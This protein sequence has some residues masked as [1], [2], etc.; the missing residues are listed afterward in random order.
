MPA[1][2]LAGTL[3]FHGSLRP[4][5]SAALSSA[6]TTSPVAAISHVDGRQRLIFHVGAGVQVLV[7]RA[8]DDLRRH[9]ADA[10]GLAQ[11]AAEIHPVER[12]DD[13]GLAH[14][15]ARI[16]AEHVERR[17]VMRRMIGR[18][19][20]ALLEVGDHAGAEPLG[21]L[22]AR[23]PELGLARAAAEH[24]HRL[25]ARLAAA[26]PLRRRDSFAGRGGCRRLEALHVGPFRLLVELLLLEAGVETDVDRRGRRRAR[27]HV[28]A[29]HRFHQRIRRGR[30]VVPLDDRANVGALVARGV[31]PVDPGPALFG[32]D[33]TGGA[34]H[35][36]RHAVA[37]GVEQA[38]H[39]VQ[40]ADIAVQHAGHRLAGRLGIAVRDRDRM[41]L[42][43][44]QDDAGI[45]VAEMIDEAVVKAAIARA[46]V[47]ADIRDAETP[48]HLRRDIAAPGHAAVGF[49]FQSVET[50]A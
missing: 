49:S 34:E 32:G 21:E 3:A 26:P 47:E 23:L 11:R 33:R 40:Q 48:Q 35:E 22:D 39:A 14:Q 19:H 50:H 30:L 28:G 13:I 16:L 2:V 4:S 44:A 41:V 25:L 36:H 31:D 45:L 37:P 42:V 6:T 7:E 17:T 8:G 46:G 29:R 9:L 12:E 15:L 43:Q 38:H 10:L 27:Q 24:D 20:R 18:E 5:P 1:L